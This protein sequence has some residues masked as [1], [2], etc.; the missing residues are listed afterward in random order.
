[1]VG[2]NGQP[3]NLQFKSAACDSIECRTVTLTP[4][5]P[6]KA[7]KTYQLVVSGTPGSPNPLATG[8]RAPDETLLDGDG[9]ALQG[10]NLVTA[11]GA[12]TASA[13]HATIGSGVMHAARSAAAATPAL[14]PEVSTTAVDAVLADEY[15]T[16]SSQLEQLAGAGDAWAGGAAAGAGADCVQRADAGHSA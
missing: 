2:K 11:I 7:N 4:K 9:D 16:D 3:K 12:K 13:R 14:T 15:A 1:M 5:K 10:G 8:L 6:L